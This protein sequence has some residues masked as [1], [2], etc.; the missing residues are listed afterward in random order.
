MAA[1]LRE[2]NA[3][4]GGPFETSRLSVETVA[5]GRAAAAAFLGC[6][7]GE[8]V[9]GANMTT[10]TMHA[11]R[12]LC[13]ELGPGDEVLVTGLDHDANVAPWALAAADRGAI[14][15]FAGIDREAC[16]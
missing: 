8:V 12:I 13:R 1:Y 6:E 2:R 11:S 14:V 4:L 7:P 10:L 16:L 5:A 9:F 3:N 15:R